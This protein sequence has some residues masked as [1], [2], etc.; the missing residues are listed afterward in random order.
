MEQYL[1]VFLILAASLFYA[2]YKLW[3]SIR[4]NPKGNSRCAGCTGCALKDILENNNNATK[5]S[6]HNKKSYGQEK[7]GRKF[8]SNK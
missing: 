1:I 3:Q 4:S 6:K 7:N 2:A 8:G 5:C